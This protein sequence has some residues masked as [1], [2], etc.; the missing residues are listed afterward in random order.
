MWSTPRLLYVA[1]LYIRNVRLLVVP[2]LIGSLVGLIIAILIS[3]SAALSSFLFREWTYMSVGLFGAWLLGGIVFWLGM[4]ISIY[5]S[6]SLVQ[7]RDITLDEAVRQV[8]R[9]LGH[10]ITVIFPLL[11]LEKL[12]GFFPFLGPLL[13]SAVDLWLISS[14]LHVIRNGIYYSLTSPIN[15]LG[16]IFRKDLGAL[17]LMYVLI[18]FG[19]L[20]PIVSFIVFP[21]VSIYYAYTVKGY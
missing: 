19:V 9:R 17:V 2:P 5:A 3:V 15:Y 14:L 13:V 12:L 4:S 18:L 20:L 11:L 10:V 7:G 21:F 1:E 8:M 16:L 6:W